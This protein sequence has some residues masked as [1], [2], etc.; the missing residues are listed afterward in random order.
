MHRSMRRWTSSHPPYYPVSVDRREHIPNNSLDCSRS[1]N[2]NGTISLSR[3]IQALALHLLE[4]ILTRDN[5]SE[6]NVLTIQVRSFHKLI[7][8]EQDISH[9]F[10]FQLTVMKN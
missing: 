10:H 6:D 4:N 8:S 3:P 5:L 9:Q 2:L 1:S 7:Q